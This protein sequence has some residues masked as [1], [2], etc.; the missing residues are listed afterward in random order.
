M[1]DLSA[2]IFHEKVAKSSKIKVRVPLETKNS[3]AMSESFVWG[4]SQ[5]EICAPFLRRRHPLKP[6]SCCSEVHDSRVICV[7]ISPPRVEPRCL[8]G[9]AIER[10]ETSTTFVVASSPSQNHS[11][12]C[13]SEVEL[14]GELDCFGDRGN[15]SQPPDC[16]SQPRRVVAVTAD[17]YLER[18]RSVLADG[19]HSL[20]CQGKYLLLAPYH[21]LMYSATA[22]FV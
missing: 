10:V 3:D 5:M 22:L 20:S 11:A 9:P 21:N 4:Y 13:C 1:K 18:H 15:S 12:G 14:L 17:D 19:D 7:P 6:V 2:L 8:E 16:P